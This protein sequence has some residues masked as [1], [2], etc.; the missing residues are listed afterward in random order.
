M[1][2]LAIEQFTA[3]LKLSEDE[4]HDM[5]SINLARV[6]IQVGKH[7][8]AVKLCKLVKLSSFQSQCH[9][10]LALF[11][12]IKNSIACFLNIIFICAYKI[13]TQIIRQM[14]FQHS[15]AAK[16]YE[17]SY[18]TYE[19]TLHWLANSETDK[20]NILCAM[21]AIAYRFQGVDAV[22]T[23]L[24]QCIQIQPPTIA[25]FLATAALGIL[26]NDHNLTSLVLKELKPYENHHEYGHHTVTLSA[27]HHIIQGDTTEAVRVLTKAIHRHPGK[28]FNSRNKFLCILSWALHFTSST[29]DRATENSGAIDVVSLLRPVF[30]AGYCDN[31]SLD[32]S[33]PAL[34][35]CIVTK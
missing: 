9:L 15:C 27:Y 14:Y 24:F 11:K 6:L 7:D 22:K 30:E 4:Q 33:R 2:S 18:N 35:M 5:V 19:S 29:G 13:I 8:E 20:A 31:I 17:E 21:A 23:L 34:S 1:Y 3:A 26:H 32:A 25:G 28:R 16:T 10:A 12:G